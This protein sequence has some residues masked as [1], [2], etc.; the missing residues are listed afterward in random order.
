MEPTAVELE[1]L[2]L[3]ERW[4]VTVSELT[5]L[6]HSDERV[7]RLLVSEGVVD[8]TGA[9]PREWRFNGVQVLRA[10]RAVRLQRDLQLNLAGAALALDLLE[11]IELLRVR[12]RALQL[13]TRI[14]DADH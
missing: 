8:P 5:Q 9:E 6:C 7:V 4:T 1:A 10:R 13:L 2:V 11:E 14:A 12:V 3:D